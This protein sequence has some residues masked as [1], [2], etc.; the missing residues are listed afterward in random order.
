MAGKMRPNARHGPHHGPGKVGLTLGVSDSMAKHIIKNAG[1]KSP[2]S[3]EQL[4]LLKK[5]RDS[6]EIFDSTKHVS[7]LDFYSRYNISRNTWLHKE[8]SKLPWRRMNRG[9]K[10]AVVG[11]PLEELKG[12][13][14]KIVMENYIK[15]NYLGAKKVADTL[16]VSEGSVNIWANDKEGSAP[17]VRIMGNKVPKVFFALDRGEL[18]K[19]KE[20]YLREI[21]KSLRRRH[22]KHHLERLGIIGW[23]SKETGM[24]KRLL[25]EYLKMFGSAKRKFGGAKISD[26]EVTDLIVA[27]HNSGGRM[28]DFLKRM[29]G[30]VDAGN[31]DGF[32]RAF[33]TGIE[34]AREYGRSADKR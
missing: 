3:D 25:G 31:R 30:Y 24:N 18:L 33:N 17:A 21:S 1:F 6:F 10:L 15:G 4:A 7:K 26:S 16:G 32:F 5:R 14:E 22:L 34:I 27:L 23:L 19:H 8:V 12:I 11:L 28:E 29:R 20:E 13:I 9:G 2:I